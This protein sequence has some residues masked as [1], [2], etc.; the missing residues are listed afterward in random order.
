[1]DSR[2]TF[3]ELNPRAGSFTAFA[4]VE[5]SR[6]SA[7]SQSLSE[8]KV[9]ASEGADG[10]LALTLDFSQPNDVMQVLADTISFGGAI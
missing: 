10:F 4:E 2:T 9:N 7:S 3:S 6:A 8:G 5:T 1:M